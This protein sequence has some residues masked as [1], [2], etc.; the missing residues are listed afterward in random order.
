MARKKICDE[1][2]LGSGRMGASVNERTDGCIKNRKALIRRRS[3]I[4]RKLKRF[5]VCSAILLSFIVLVTLVFGVFHRHAPLD[6]NKQKQENGKLETNP[7]EAAD[8]TP[9]VINGVHELTVEAGGNIS[10]KSGVSAYD[11]RDGEIPFTVDNSAVN[12]NIPGDYPVIYS[13]ADS[14]GNRAQ[15]ET[16]LHVISTDPPKAPKQPAPETPAPE[17]PDRET[18]VYAMADEILGQIITAGMSQYQQAEAIYWWVH[19]NISYVDTSEK[20]DWVKAAYTGLSTRR[21]DCFVYASVSKAMLTRAGIPNMDIAKIPTG[22]LHYWNLIDIGEGWHH[23]DTTRRMDGATF[24]YLT[25]AEL[26]EY[27]NAH[28]RSHAYDK[29]LYPAIQ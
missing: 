10:Y 21:G 1:R 22:T 16:I 18:A 24:F 3:R 27:S 19:G 13:A 9:P 20:D 17:M 29:S 2:R 5:L 7:P 8:V 15:E 26:M 14:A 28:N 11:D 25:D 23:F 4:R 12:L 6:K